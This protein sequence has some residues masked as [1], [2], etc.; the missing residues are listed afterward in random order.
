MAGH[1]E[2]KDVARPVVSILREFWEVAEGIKFITRLLENFLSFSALTGILISVSLLC[3][4]DFPL[5]DYNILFFWENV[6]P[7]F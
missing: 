7:L 4:P 2:V 5:C 3:L 6:N 1:P